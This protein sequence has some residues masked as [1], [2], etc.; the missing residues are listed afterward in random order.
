[1]ESDHC[2]DLHPDVTTDYAL[3]SKPGRLVLDKKKQRALNHM[4]PTSMIKNL[5]SRETG[6]QPRKRQ[7][8]STENSGEESE[9]LLL[10]GQ[11]RVRKSVPTLRT[12]EIR[13]DPESSDND[14]NEY[15]TSSSEVEIVSLLR[16]NSVSNHEVITLSD[17]NN[18]IDNDLDESSDEGI[19]DEDIQA[20]MGDYNDG[21]SDIRETNLID[22]MLSRTRTIGNG[23]KRHSTTRAR[24][25][26]KKYA[27]DIVTGGARKY[28]RTRQTLLSFDKH[29]GTSGRRESRGS[30]SMSTTDNKELPDAFQVMSEAA[31]R[32][33][34]KEKSKQRS[35]R[36]RAN[37]LY[38]FSGKD[39]T[40]IVSGRSEITSVSVDTEKSIPASSWADAFR[41]PT[42][43]GRTVIQ[44]LKGNSR[45][46]NAKNYHRETSP[47]PEN[48]FSLDDDTI[49]SIAPV[50]TNIH[51]LPLGISFG[52]ETY[53]GKRRLDQL[54]SAVSMT[55]RAPQPAPCDLRGYDLRPD[56]GCDD[57]LTTLQ[58]ICDGFLE[59]S[60]GLPEVDYAEHLREWDIITRVV[61]Q[62]LSWFYDTGD[63]E[64]RE[65]LQ[66]IVE[67][68]ADAIVNHI[69]GLNL[70]DK[71]LDQ[72]VL[73]LDWF[74]VELLA[75]A[76]CKVTFSRSNTAISNVFHKALSLFIDHLMELGPLV[77]LNVVA[78]HKTLTS[79]TLHQQCAELWVCLIHLLA[80]FP[81]QAPS[82]GTRPFWSLVL[83][84]L[85][86]REEE[87][88][89]KA[90][91][92]IWETIFCLSAL[93]QFSVY[94]MTT[95]HPRLPAAWALVVFAMKKI[96]L[97]AYPVLDQDLRAAALVL[98]DRYIG[99][100]TFRCF[101]LCDKWRWQLDDA[102][103]LFNE[104]GEVFR[105][106]KFANLRH[107]KPD[108]PR[109]MLS[110]DWSA[111]SKGTKRDSAFTLFL[112]LIVKAAKPE[113]HVAE[114]SPK[115]KKLLSLAIPVG[116]LPFTKATPPSQQDLSMLF[117]RYSAVAIAI[118][119]DRA[120]CR[121]RVSH[122]RTYLAF[123]DADMSARMAVI[124]GMMNLANLIRKLELHLD[125]MAEWIADISVAL[126]D[127]LKAVPMPL[128]E[129]QIQGANQEQQ[130]QLAVRCRLHICIQMLLSSIRHILNLFKED[131]EYPEPTL[132][133]RYSTRVD[134]TITN[135]LH[136]S[137]LEIFIHQRPHPL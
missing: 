116:S 109:F 22:W 45:V 20:Y 137:Q 49:P 113:E 37:G 125:A 80:A 59:F 130:R 71:S 129:L 7:L 68:Y 21:Q 64:V 16:P 15:E 1:M 36:R 79:S 110:S 96:R 103:E 4:M 93:S 6:R 107:E 105:S 52:D 127:E 29:T 99:V 31:N 135:H 58:R 122:A 101:Q 12:Q 24:R 74:T 84:C 94:G 112:K 61:C 25:P 43:L 124:R 131:R 102:S 41:P 23:K 27:L 115:F 63:Q 134:F 35:A 57:F 38:V 97:A 13:G 95:S 111:L 17:S 77:S 123:N 76:G 81:A 3:A 10:P 89:L 51:L 83:E 55:T 8:S 14:T 18:D 11:T 34:R 108:C 106:R 90:S 44:Q 65:Q 66:R 73:Q 48:D 2:H 119:L 50:T 62:M 132:L 69:R 114:L 86:G 104:L 128:I 54:I 9:G 117:N 53:V 88:N 92:K 46:S 98:R 56:M 133:G 33:G 32:L 47:G 75:R 30:R 5:I 118:Y 67:K 82:R 87:S 60:T 136:C 120:S 19:A 126:S 70:T 28:G 85:R 40:R 100:I 42:S 26:R 72:T 121:T 39:N 78:Q 91:E